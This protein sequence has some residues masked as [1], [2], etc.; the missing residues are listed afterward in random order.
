[1]YFMVNFQKYSE[2]PSKTLHKMCALQ[3]MI[4]SV[5]QESKFL[6]NVWTSKVS[7]KSFET[8]QLTLSN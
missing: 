6:M 7:K 4:F 3:Q 2:M 1:M 5:L 8:F